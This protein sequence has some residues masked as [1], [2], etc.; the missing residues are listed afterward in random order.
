MCSSSGS[1]VPVLY[2]K[3]LV[4]LLEVNVNCNRVAK[5][6]LDAV[7]VRC[8]ERNVRG[9]SLRRHVGRG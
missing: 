6:D 1:N 5:S 7:D 8:G 4:D 9:S 3:G 2:A